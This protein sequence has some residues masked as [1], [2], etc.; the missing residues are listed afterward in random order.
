MQHSADQLRNPVL[1]EGDPRQSL[2][3][4]LCIDDDPEIARIWQIR[5]SR[6]GIT[7]VCAADGADGFAMAREK[8]PD[9]I[10]LDLCLPY[11]DGHQ[12]LTRLR[13]DPQ[14]RDI[15]VLM[16]TGGD[17]RAVQ[18]QASL[19]RADDYLSKPIN[20]AELLE[21]L[22]THIPISRPSSPN[23]LEACDG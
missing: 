22:A 11:E 3:T 9:V 10:L 1:F 15:P 13:S 17:A 21:R 23:D 7:V 20:F 8:S 18:R 4:V 12:V 6:Y 2:S 14:T 5:L 19:H 16:L